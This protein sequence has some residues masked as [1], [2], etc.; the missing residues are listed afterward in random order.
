MAKSMFQCNPVKTTHDDYFT[1]KKAWEDI[2]QFIPREKTIWESCM[3]NSV[4]NSPIYLQELG[5]DV[6]WNVNED[7]FLEPK[8]ENSICVT[9]LP[10]TLKKEIFQ[11]LKTIDQPFIIL[12]PSTCLHTKY[13]YELFKD[14][15]I[16]LIIPSTK[17]HFD[18]YV[19][20]VKIEG[21]SNCSFY[22]LYICYEAGLDHDIN[23]I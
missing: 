2:S 19:D 4:S 1:R 7:I 12:A 17:R 16:Q 20:H 9:N 13:C 5:F 10:F 14:E 11:H 3:L 15:K 8:R 6:E 18:K 21:P 23:F 22:T